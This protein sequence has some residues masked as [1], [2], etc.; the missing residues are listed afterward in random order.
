MINSVM[1]DNFV[2]LTRIK[3]SLEKGLKQ[4]NADLEKLQPQILEIFQEQGISMMN[5]HGMTLYIQSQLWAKKAP[6]VDIMGAIKALEEAHL[7]EYTKPSIN[8]QGLSKHFREAEELNHEVP[9]CLAGKI[10]VTRSYK[11]VGRNG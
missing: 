3:R 1:L 6:E 5:I 11:I 2:E 4:V 10:D 8:V 7:E 9:Q